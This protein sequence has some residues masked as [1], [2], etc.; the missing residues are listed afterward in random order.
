MFG[1]L[2]HG[3]MQPWGF[4]VREEW[5]SIFERKTIFTTRSISESQNSLTSAG[6]SVTILLCRAHVVPTYGSVRD[7]W[8]PV[9][10][11][12]YLSSCNLLTRVVH[13]MRHGSP[14]A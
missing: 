7:T 3:K 9:R 10:R 1:L 14:P 4:R 6:S 11:H 2:A 5:E 13:G 8:L 12:R